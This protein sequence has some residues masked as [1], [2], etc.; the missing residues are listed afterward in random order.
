[1]S[2]ENRLKVH[3]GWAKLHIQ[4][5]E[6]GGNDG[7]V[8]AKCAP[9]EFDLQGL[10]ERMPKCLKKRVVAYEDA[11]AEMKEGLA[12]LDKACAVLGFGMPCCVRAFVR[13]HACADVHKHAQTQ[14]L[15]NACIRKH[16]PCKHLHESWHDQ[17]V[18]STAAPRLDL[19]FQ[20]HFVAQ[21]R[22]LPHAHQKS[23]RNVKFK[24]T[25]TFMHNTQ[26]TMV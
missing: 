15:M 21:R 3:W 19:L 20:T 4:R 24:T 10:A 26:N 22:V 7:D 5:L 17:P 2:N 16:P 6:R 1:V 23:E 25:F 9:V 14:A 18:L 8:D 11:C 12:R 13:T